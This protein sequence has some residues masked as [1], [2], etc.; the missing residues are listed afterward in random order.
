MVTTPP[1]E[2]TAERPDPVQQPTRGGLMPV[3]LTEVGVDHL[4]RRARSA[5]RRRWP[6]RYRRRDLR[7]P[8]RILRRARAGRSHRFG[9]CRKPPASGGRGHRAAVLAASRARW[10]R[11]G[12]PHEQR[13]LRGSVA[14]GGGARGPYGRRRTSRTC[15]ERPS[16]CSRWEST[17]RRWRPVR[18]PWVSVG[19]APGAGRQGRGLGHAERG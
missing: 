5:R 3:V 9:G 19:A 1:F 7:R 18:R 10:P 17:C 8:R 6:G 13:H 14:G 11:A 4:A 12:A 2:P 16:S 15:P